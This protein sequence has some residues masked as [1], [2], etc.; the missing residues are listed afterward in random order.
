MTKYD[1]PKLY[2]YVPDSVYI[3][4]EDWIRTI[5]RDELNKK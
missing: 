5:V 1:R 2:A 3:D 4:L